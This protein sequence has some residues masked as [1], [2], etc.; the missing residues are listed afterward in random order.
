V[1]YIECDVRLT[2]DGAPVLLHDETLDRTTNGSGPVAEATLEEVRKLDAG[3]GERVP[4]LEEFLAL[5]RGR[6]PA[7]L[8]LKAEGTPR[9]VLECVERAGMLDSVIFTSGSTERLAEVRRLS[10]VATFEHIFS[11]PPPDALER[12]LSVGASRVS[13]N[14][15]H[16]RKE[17]VEAAHGVGL[18]VVTWTPNTQAEMLAAI[19]KGVDL[20]CTDRPDVL[21]RLLGR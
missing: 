4:T 17:F 14:H 2:A 5:V 9:V 8:E 13:V 16:L 3:K 11:D 18:L 7:H 20:V 15:R 19:A 12:A 6:C 1:D 21:L 10:R